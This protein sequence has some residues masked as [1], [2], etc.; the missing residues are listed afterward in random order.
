MGAFVL[1]I[2]GAIERKL[3]LLCLLVA[4]FPARAQV[5][6]WQGTLDLPV[7]EE[8]APDSNPAF[9]QFAT[10]RFNY[11]YTL[12]TR[13]TGERR[14]HSLRAVYLENEYLKCSVLPDIG[15][16][17]YTCMD[18]I[19]GQPMFYANPSIKKALIGYRGAW[20]AFGVEFNFPVSHNWMSMSPVDFTFAAHEDGSASIT[21]GNI[22]RVYGMEW[23]VELVLRPRST[24]LEQRVRLSNRSDVRQRFYWWS[25]AGVRIWDDSRVEYPMRFT[26]SHGFT[27]VARWP[28][29]VSGKDL[30]VIKNQT[31]GPVSVFVHGSRED[32][33]GIWHPHTNAG[34]AHYARYEE[35][36]AKK[37]W[38][39]GVDVDGLDWRKALSDDNSAYAEVQGGLFR[40]QETY[41][42]LEP[43]KEIRFTEYWMPARGTGGISRANLAGVVHLERRDGSVE[44]SLNVN[45][46]MNGATVRVMEGTAARLSETMDLTPERTW[47]GLVR[48]S[49]GASL[50][51][52][53]FELA[54]SSGAVALR[55]TEG[56]YDW[57]P[58]S[59]IHVGPQSNW[60]APEQSARTEDDWLQLGTNQELDGEKL[61]AARD[62]ETALAKFPGS[63]VLL[64]ASGRLLVSLQRFEDGEPRLA[65]AHAR[66]TTDGE[67]SYYLGMAEEGLGRERAAVHAYEEAMR[68]PDYRAAAALRLGELKAGGGKVKEAG[69]LFMSRAVP[70]AYDERALEESAAISGAVAPSEDVIRGAKDLLRVYPLSAFLREMAREP[71]MQHLAADPYRVLNLAEEFARVGMYGKAVE[72]LSRDYPPV[73]ADQREPGFGLPQENA[74]VVYFRGYC[75]EK[76]GKTG[77][78]KE[79]YARASRLSTLYVFPS[80]VAD[81]AAL[82]AALRA[83]SHDASAHYLLGTWFFARAMTESALREWSAARALNPKIPALDASLGLE[84]LHERRDFGAAL[85]VFEEGIRNDPENLVNYSGGL[86]ALSLLDKPARARVDLL[87]RYPNLKKTP[88]ELAYELALNRAEAADFAGAKDLFRGR[89]FGREEGGTNVRQVWVEVNLLE[90]MSLAKSR[91]CEQA[92]AEVDGLGVA[93]AGLEFTRDGLTPWI[94]TARMQYFLGEIYAACGKKNLAEAKFSVA[95]G[96]Q[97]VA[98][99]VWARAAAKKLTGYDAVQWTTRLNQGIA[100]AEV[101]ARNGSGWSNYVL[102][103]LR[104]AAGERERGRENLRGVFLFPDTRLSWHLSRMGLAGLDLRAEVSCGRN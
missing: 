78:A 25:N 79:D 12:R 96:A 66:N 80:T 92:L 81:K 63:F 8:G 41:A 36:P 77:L 70:S 52:C 28:V 73:P 13:I 26:A 57:T 14:E 64:K 31:D 48:A 54:D 16:H 44:V 76:L 69:E 34:T 91:K 35:L 43:R 4:A 50:G 5:R 98:D 9:D 101:S 87:E 46:R 42:F 62:Y 99:L 90:A 72:I 47:T 104:V 58:E 82:V 51:K 88:T 27:E 102:G 24:V 20:A 103:I 33:M 61:T 83:N 40:N 59:E 89:F 97:G 68:S 30:S 18:K 95:A 2:G 60:R 85:Q 37:I 15:G 71:D 53:T 21:V 93:V 22:D 74:L 6:V 94:G 49:T 55:Q 10:D 39:W 7:Y 23:N 65:A 29:D 100:E 32:F 56:E 45:E 67:L 11:P 19:N 75:R 38:S 17:V 84:L 1:G 3:F 86:A